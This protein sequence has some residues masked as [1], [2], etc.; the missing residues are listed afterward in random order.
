VRRLLAPVALLA[1]AWLATGCGSAGDIA[2]G[3]KVSGEALTVYSSLP[4]P[5]RGA[6]QDIVDGEKL[7]L[8]EAGGV[9]GAYKVNFVSVDEAP[10]SRADAAEGAAAAAREAI[11]DPQVIAVIGAAASETA[12]V[13][14]PLYNAA[15]ILHV[16][17]GAGYSG[18]TD[19][20]A[21]GEPE[22]WHPSGR[23]TFARLI[24]DDRAQ[25]PA[26]LA[27]VR[28]A[29]G[30]RGR[31]LRVAV[32]QEPSAAA[33]ELVAALRES[34]REAGVRLVGDPAR[35]DAVI[36]A[37]EDPENAAGVA[38]ALAR[39]APQALIVLPDALTRAGIAGR[40]APAARRRSLLVSAA[41]EP[42]STPALRDFEQRLRGRLGRDPGPYAALGYE[43]MRSV[44]DAI[45][46][47]GKR[48]GR[49]QAV[50]DAYLVP[51]RR[52]D[53]LLGDYAIERDG[54]RDT[55]PLQAFTAFRLRGGEPVYLPLR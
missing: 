19:P 24:A 44:L 41:P 51:G 18:F 45:E 12:M 42:G 13:A 23:H 5:G 48:A 29:S 2:R 40:L 7:A 30:G 15:G 1:A 34:A 47:A 37:G 32:E 6:S 25:A 4:D 17:P 50:I 33:D 22:R 10:G 8:F 28:S 21:P 31:P 27:A 26:L 35:A 52:S 9:A 55:P 46:R 36:Y 11:A 53:T 3:G 20:V 43:A 38:E 39:E 16:S 54:E 49:R 14:I